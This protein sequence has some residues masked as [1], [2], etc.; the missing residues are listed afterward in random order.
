ME[1]R[2]CLRC[3]ETKPAGVFTRRRTQRPGKLVSE[4]TPCKVERNRRYRKEN[5]D[6]V[7]KIE[8]RSKLKATYGI[9]VEQYDEMLKAQGGGCAICGATEPDGRTRHFPI[10]HCHT[11]N[12]VRGLLCTKCNRGLGLFNDDAYRLERAASYLKKV[13]K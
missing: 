1:T 4:C 3:N 12:V 6:L 2:V 10:D 7:K 8:R 11:T 9:S 5:Q 13:S